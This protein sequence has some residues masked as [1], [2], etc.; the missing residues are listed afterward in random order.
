MKTNRYNEC[1]GSIADEEE[2]YVPVHLGGD[3]WSTWES[4]NPDW[5]VNNAAGEKINLY[6]LPYAVSTLYLAPPDGNVLESDLTPNS[7]FVIAKI[8]G[9]ALLG[10]ITL[11]TTDPKTGDVW[12]QVQNS[13]IPN[14]AGLTGN[15]GYIKNDPNLFDADKALKDVNA[16]YQDAENS[17][18]PDIQAKDAADQKKI[19]AAGG[20]WFAGIPNWVVMLA[21]GAVVIGAVAVSSNKK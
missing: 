20:Q 5:I 15:Y 17:V 14:S 2:F 6:A 16:A 11:Y 12:F 3:E 7:G 1:M 4:V 10:T 18:M 9:G 21:G 19:D 13:K 8:G